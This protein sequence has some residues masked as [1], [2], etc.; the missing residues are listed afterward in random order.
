[1]VN[2]K[3]RTKPIKPQDWQGESAKPILFKEI[4]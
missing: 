2:L 4:K 3:G 1:M